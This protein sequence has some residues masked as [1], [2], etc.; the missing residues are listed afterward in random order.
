MRIRTKHVQIGLLTVLTILILF[1]PVTQARYSFDGIPFEIAAQGTVNGGIYIDGGHGLGFPP[2]VQE[3]DVPEG[4]V[5]WA[6]L[7]VGIWGGTEK[8]DGWV[9]ADLN[10][11]NLGKVVLLGE[12]DENPNIYCAGHGVYWVYYDVTGAT[13]NGKNIAT[14]ETSHG[15]PGN[16]LDGRVYCAVLATVYEDENAPEISYWIYEGN[17]N[18]HGSGWSG[19]EGSTNDG[20]TVNFNVPLDSTDPNHADLTVVYLT[21]SKGLPNYLQFNG[22]QLGTTP[23]Y[24]LD[25]GY[26][27]GVTDIANAISGDASTGTGERTSYFDIEFFNVVEHIQADNVLTFLRGR[28]LNGDGQIS[29]D[30]GE[31]YLHPVIASLA[32]EHKTSV[33]SKPDLT[34]DVTM[35]DINLIDG[36]DIE[37]PVI[38]GNPGRLCEEDF[39]IGL[40]VDGIRTTTISARMDASG[41]CR[42]TVNWHA[43]AGSHL[44]EITADPENAVEE[45]DEDNNAR[46]LE[47][48]VKTRPDLTVAIGEPEKLES[49]NGLVEASSLLFLLAIGRSGKKK[50]TML[51]MLMLMS[52]LLL[53]VC[54]C[55]CIGT[56]T[57][58]VQ[59]DYLIPVVITNSGEAAACDFDVNLYLNDE[60]TVSILVKELD[61]T[62]SIEEE[63]KIIVTGG[64]YK[65]RVTVDEKN[66][67]IES[68]EVN[69][70]N[71]VIYNF[72]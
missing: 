41:V 66:R 13:T 16:K 45:S 67:V 3:F 6:R 31:D 62:S 58:I 38:V 56:R 5:R 51:L 49:G 72:S 32:L 28:D 64:E 59:T 57:E 37:I 15:E 21:G 7:Y 25:M 55:G 18:L 43:A 61:G 34:I 30:E 42:T 12:N 69:N 33:S 29:D 71:E 65:L 17:E 4:S 1:I 27:E 47:V 40:D 19:K 2:Y 63:L 60:K 68:D 35:D 54:L 44:L 10:G 9:R 22:H 52:V 50:A 20:S 23:Q 24:L 70:A 48:I 39:K 36:Y 53:S 11:E 14:I 46:V 8:Y 26:S